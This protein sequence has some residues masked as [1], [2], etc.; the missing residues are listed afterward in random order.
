MAMKAFHP[1]DSSSACWVHQ[2]RTGSSQMTS[3]KSLK[4]DEDRAQVQISRIDS[5]PFV[6]PL[7]AATKVLGNG[8]FALVAHAA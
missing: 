8:T 6:K 5:S 4:S 7:S 3:A 2:N 1:I